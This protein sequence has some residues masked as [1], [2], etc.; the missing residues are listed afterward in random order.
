MGL[1][2]PFQLW[3]LLFILVAMST[4]ALYG[5]FLATDA[6]RQEAREQ[7]FQQY[8]RQQLLMAEQASAA[9]EVFFVSLNRSLG[10]VTSLFEDHPVDNN[11]AREIQGSLFKLNESL[12]DSAIIDLVVFDSKGTVVAIQPS[13]PYTLGRNY[14]WRDYYLW[15]RDTGKPGQMYV[16]PFLKLEGGQ[17]RGDKAL[18]VAQGIYSPDSSFK[19]VAMFTVNFDELA[20]KHILPVR[21]GEN[22]YAWLADINNK[23]LLVDPHG[24]VA[25]RSFE[26]AFL[27]QWPK[28]YSLLTSAQY[29]GSGTDWYSY[30][31]PTDHSQAVRKLLGYQIL[32]LSDHLWF[33]GVATPEREVD[34]LLSSF[35]RRQETV[36][37]TLV[38]SILAV[39]VV[40]SGL[41]LAWNRMLSRRVDARTSALAK[42]RSQLEH[43]FDELLESKK[44]AAVGHLALGLT[45][46]I[47]NPLSAIRMNIKMIRKK[48]QPEGRL[49]EHFSIIDDE[50]LRLNRLLSD[51][52][53]F[54]RPG[55]L[56]LEKQNL[57]DI[58]QRVN[59]L[60]TQRFEEEQVAIETRMPNPLLVVCD[61]EQI[62]QVLLNLIINALDAM[63]EIETE[64]QLS[65]VG[66][67]K[68]NQVFIRVTDNGCGIRPEDRDKL[69]D[70]FYTTKPAGGGL[71]LCN[72]QGILLRHQGA[73]DIV[74]KEGPGTCFRIRLPITPTA[75]AN[76]D[77]LTD[78]GHF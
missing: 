24:A 56:R 49:Q 34:K 16:S 6:V 76:K 62:E 52:M 61:A 30:E 48:W 73:V 77:D 7:F 55:P 46:E 17:N 45:H 39:T 58:V 33:I 57:N 67:C 18:I 36:S 68:G 3:T 71:G 1:I 75:M 31:D 12:A 63:K 28:L 8:N 9:L 14:A 22:G 23:T 50:I 4:T 74:E 59:L 35:L 5:I 42:A 65:I 2:R 44:L 60:L 47:R 20:R 38:I 72:L 70:P 69:F 26:E 21:L 41:L 29:G 13:D 19:G 27:P 40:V 11:R 78:T 15:A 53:D 64:K 32:E 37:L 54:A 10:L 66:S 51:V 25:G 43:T